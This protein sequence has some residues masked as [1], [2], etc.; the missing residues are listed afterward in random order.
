MKLLPEIGKKESK[1]LI[2]ILEEMKQSLQR[3]HGKQ[4]QDSQR[5]I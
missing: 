4:S 1:K 2:I 3:N 5:Q